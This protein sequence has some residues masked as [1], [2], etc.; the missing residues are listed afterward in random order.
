MSDS[1]SRVELGMESAEQELEEADVTPTPES[2]FPSEDVQVG[3]LRIIVEGQARQNEYHLVNEWKFVIDARR[4]PVE[5]AHAARCSGVD[6][7]DDR[8]V[9]TI[10]VTL[11]K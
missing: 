9:S 5:A 4:G 7:D 1:G 2:E 3:R 11:P 6:S 10:R 8:G